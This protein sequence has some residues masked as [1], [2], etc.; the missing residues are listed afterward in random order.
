MSI[1]AIL[2]R[3]Q[4]KGHEVFSGVDSINIVLERSRGNIPNAFDD[5]AHAVMR[6]RHA[7]WLHRIWP[8]TTDP[9]AYW[10]RHP[11]HVEGTAILAPGQY[12]GAYQEGLHRGRPA[13][14]QVG[15]VDVFRDRD[16][17]GNPDA[18]GPRYSGLFGVNI[19]NA[20][21][22]RPSMLVEKWSAGCVVFSSD[23]DHQEFLRLVRVSTH[24]YGPR[25]TVT[26]IQDD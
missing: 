15:P 7:G 17:D 19:H 2:H 3:V 23:T 25:V 9:G 10:L 26:L 14:V 24:Q 12:R 1:P 16:Q 18:F 5:L 21:R 20:S 8:I 13:L 11:M 6:T 22:N 4:A